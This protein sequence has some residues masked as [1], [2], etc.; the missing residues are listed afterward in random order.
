MSNLINWLKKFFHEILP[1]MCNFR[2]RVNKITCMERMVGMEGDTVAIPHLQV[3]RLLPWL[4]PPRNR[5]TTWVTWATWAIWATWTRNHSWC[6]TAGRQTSLSSSN[7][8]SRFVQF[9][10]VHGC[11]RY[12]CIGTDKILYHKKGSDVNPQNVNVPTLNVNV[13]VSFNVYVPKMLPGSHAVWQMV[14]K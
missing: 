14:S 13:N 12:K 8:V 1:L 10:N 4:H 2:E 5:W 9:L 3:Y 6:P 7:T 11:F